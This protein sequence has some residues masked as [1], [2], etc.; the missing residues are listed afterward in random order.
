MEVG[1]EGPNTAKKETTSA[2]FLETDERPRFCI[3]VTYPIRPPMWV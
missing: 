1:L 2:E 3:G